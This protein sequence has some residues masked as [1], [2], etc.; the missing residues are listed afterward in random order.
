[1]S[2]RIDKTNRDFLRGS[3]DEE[4]HGVNWDSVCSPKK[5]GVS[6]IKKCLGMNQTLVGKC[7]WW[8]FNEG[9]RSST[10]EKYGSAA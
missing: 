4:A 2:K 3:E 9:E 5:K 10:S 1:M 8:F 7:S 6:R